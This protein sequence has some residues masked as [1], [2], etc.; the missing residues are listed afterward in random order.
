MG[1]IAAG[2][3]G[4]AFECSGRADAAEGALGQLDAAGTLVFVGTGAQPTR[5]NHNR[6]IV[7]ELEAIG[8]F[9]YSARG[10]GPALELLDAEALPLDLLIE[11][12]DV[13][14]S[15]VMEAMGRMARGELPAKVLVRPEA[16]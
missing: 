5:V 2:A 3:Y 7:L 12:D 10:F 14:L 15:G 4:V 8:A 16:R 1:G 6:M 9:N 13:G 11:E